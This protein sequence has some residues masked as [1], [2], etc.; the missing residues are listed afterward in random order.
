M[1]KY[2]TYQQLGELT[3]LRLSTL[4]SLVHRR[5]IP[6]VRLSSRLVLFEVDSVER[7]L[8]ERIVSTAHSTEM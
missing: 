4:Y 3:D 1:S 7:W 2:L 5:R 8:R 6:H